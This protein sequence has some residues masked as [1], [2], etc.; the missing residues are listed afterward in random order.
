MF[1]TDNR[2]LT[3]HEISVLIIIFLENEF[4]VHITY[5]NKMN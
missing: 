5:I 2:L 3:N 1:L 4:R